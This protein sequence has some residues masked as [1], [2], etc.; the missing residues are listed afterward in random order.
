MRSPRAYRSRDSERSMEHDVIIDKLLMTRLNRLNRLF[1]D[2]MAMIC[3]A[4]QLN[5]CVH[6]CTVEHARGNIFVI[7]PGTCNILYST[8]K[9][10]QTNTHTHTHTHTHPSIH[11]LFMN[12][13][14]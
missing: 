9:H 4:E 2:K 7:T 12:H 6:Y 14:K 5:F 8:P 13:K 11:H 1:I 10:K 3:L